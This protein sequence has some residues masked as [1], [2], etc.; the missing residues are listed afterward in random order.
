[1]KT[2]LV[3]I[4]LFALA[5]FTLV[6]SELTKEE[7]EAAVAEMNSSHD[8]LNIA[9]RNLSEAQLAFKSSPDS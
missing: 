9:L 6:G 2:L 8:H 7:R 1:M 5:A 4:S 3:T